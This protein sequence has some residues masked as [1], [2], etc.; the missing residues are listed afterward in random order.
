M[1]AVPGTGV[2]FFPLVQKVPS[3]APD[4]YLTMSE[5]RHRKSKKTHKKRRAYTRTH[6]HTPAKYFSQ[7][8]TV[9][10]RTHQK[11][12]S[13]LHVKWGDRHEGLEEHV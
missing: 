2:T 5:V 11:K 7:I 1:Y 12:W 6:V 9:L 4:A 10:P 13:F 3:D 8:F